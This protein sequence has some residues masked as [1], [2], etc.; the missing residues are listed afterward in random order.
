MA[1]MVAMGVMDKMA[2]GEAKV[3]QGAKVVTHPQ[4]KVE[5]TVVMEG[6]GDQVVLEAREEMVGKPGL[7]AMVAK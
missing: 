3:A 6:P 5:K 7:V 2:L 1:V 4:P